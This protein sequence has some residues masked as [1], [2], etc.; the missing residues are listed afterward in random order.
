MI[1]PAV[2]LA[3]GGGGGGGS[4]SNNT[5]TPFQLTSVIVKI[6]THGQLPTGT[7][8]GGID[9]TLTAPTG[10]TVKTAPDAANPSAMIPDSGIVEASGAAAGSNT[11]MVAVYTAAT[12]TRAARLHI[13]IV[14]AYGFDVGEFATVKCDIAP[15]SNLQSSDFSLAG[16]TAWDVPNTTGSQEVQVITTGLTPTFSAEIK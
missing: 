2:L 11:L 13:N 10:V 8:I 4:S 1:I 5:G 12:T 9:I 15:G 3:C 6:A 7:K 14:N 16:F